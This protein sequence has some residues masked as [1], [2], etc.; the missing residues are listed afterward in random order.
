MTRP[1][2][3]QSGGRKIL[4]VLESTAVVGFAA[5]T[6]CGRA[7]FETDIGPCGIAWDGGRVAGVQL[8]ER[9]AERTRARLAR[10]F[11]H[12]AEAAPPADIERIIDDIRSLLRGEARDFRAVALTLD[13]VPEFNR[14]VYEIARTIAPGETLTYGEVASRLGDRMLAR[15]VGQALG[16]NPFPIIVPCHRVLAAG[17]RTGGFSGG[18]GVTTKLR[19]LSIERAQPSGPTLFDDL[20]LV[21]RRASRT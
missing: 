13:S 16:Q 15:E 10:R 1:Q 8:P 11:P 12:W 17:G 4:Q 9:D 14:R 3:P 7:I 21:A 18:G 19:L 2:V 6:S 20:P 5:M